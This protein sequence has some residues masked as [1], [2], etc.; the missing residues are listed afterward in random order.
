MGWKLPPK[1]KVLEALGAVS[2]NKVHVLS[3]EKAEVESFD[4]SEKF[5]VI[6][7]PEKSAITSNDSGSEYGGYLGH[8]SLAF[9]MVLGVLPFDLY[10]GRKLAEVPWSKLKNRYKDHLLIIKEATIN[11]SDLDKQRMDKFV[12]WILKMLEGL[13]L[14]KP[15]EGPRTLTEFVGKE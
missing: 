10:L 3:S 8:P 9:L 11:W 14:N 7:K 2:G 12:D 13:D 5:L 4:G 1:I 6:W 15:D